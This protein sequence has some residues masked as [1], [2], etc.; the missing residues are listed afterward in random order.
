MDY[1]NNFLKTFHKTSHINT[2][3]INR[4]LIKVPHRKLSVVK[5]QMEK[6]DMSLVLIQTFK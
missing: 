1:F 6:K 5:L 4:G 3:A 2:E